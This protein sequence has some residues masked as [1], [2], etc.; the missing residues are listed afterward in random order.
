MAGH[1]KHVSPPESNSIQIFIS[2]TFTDFKVERDALLQR[3]FPALQQYARERGLEVSFAS[4][5]WGVSRHVNDNHEITQICIDEIR[6]VRARSIGVNFVGLLGQKYGYCPIPTSIEASTFD[7]LLFNC[8]AETKTLLSKWYKR[9]SNTLDKRFI[10]LPVSDVFEGYDAPK[11]TKEE[12]KAKQHEWDVEFAKLQSALRQISACGDARIPFEFIEDV[13]RS[14]TER[15]IRAALEDPNFVDNAMFIARRFSGLPEGGSKLPDKSLRRFIDV[16]GCEETG[17]TRDINASIRLERLQSSLTSDHAVNMVKTT[18]PWLG[19]HDGVAPSK[20]SEHRSYLD[21]LCDSFEAFVKASID[22]VFKSK[23]DK[24]TSVL[25]AELLHHAYMCQQK[26]IAGCGHRPETD[27]VLEYCLSHNI[28]TGNAPTADRHEMATIMFGPSGCGKTT[29]MATVISNLYDHFDENGVSSLGNRVLYRFLGTSPHSSTAR[30][31]LISLSMQ[32][33]LIANTSFDE[34]KTLALGQDDAVALFQQSLA[35]ASASQPLWLFLDSLDQLS[36][37]AAESVLRWLPIEFPSHVRVV[38]ST[39]NDKSYPHFHAIKGVV[40]DPTHHV[41]L[42]PFEEA[43]AQDILRDILRVSGRTLTRV[44]QLH[45]IYHYK[46]DPTPLFLKLA[47][48]TSKNWHSWT[49]IEECAI[50]DSVVGLIEQLFDRI[51]LQFGDVFTSTALRYVTLARSGLSLVELED[52]LSCNDTVLDSIFEWW[53]PPIRRIPPL[54]WTRIRHELGDFMV[55]RGE[56]GALVHVWFHRQ[57]IEGAQ[58][59]FGSDPELAKRAH[60]DMADYFLGKWADVSKPTNSGEPM[61]R[62]VAQQPIEF[63]LHDTVQYNF[64]KLQ[65]LPFHLLHAKRVEEALETTL[66]NVEFLLAKTRAFSVYM[67]IGDIHEAKDASWVEANVK[68]ALGVLSRTLFL[69]ANVL[70]HH[71]EELASQLLA[72]WSESLC[73]KHPLLAKLVKNIMESTAVAMWPAYVCLDGPDDFLIRTFSRHDDIVQTAAFVG[74]TGDK[75]ATSSGKVLRIWSASEGTILQEFGGFASSINGFAVSPDGSL[76][77]L[78]GGTARVFRAEGGDPVVTLPG[79]HNSGVEFVDNGQAILVGCRGGMAKNPGKVLKYSLSEP[80][81]PELVFD[82]G[83]RHQLMFEL[84]PSGKYLLTGGGNSTKLWRVDNSE[85]VAEYPHPQSVQGLGFVTEDEFWTTCD[86]R[87]LRLWRCD[88]HDEAIVTYAPFKPRLPN[89]VAA[90]V[91]VEPFLIIAVAS[92][93]KFIHLVYISPDRTQCG[94]MIVVEAHGGNMISEL[95]VS[96]CGKYLLSG[97]DEATARLWN[98]TAIL[99]STT[100]PDGA[101]N[102][103]EALAP[104]LH[105]QE[106]LMAADATGFPGHERELCRVTMDDSSNTVCTASYDKS[107]KVWSILNPCDMDAASITIPHLTSCLDSLGDAER[108]GVPRVYPLQHLAGR[109]ASWVMDVAHPPSTPQL[110]TASDDKTFGV[111]SFREGLPTAY[112]PDRGAAM[113]D[114]SSTRLERAVTAVALSDD[115]E[116]L[117]AAES[118]GQITVYERDMEH[119][120]TPIHTFMDLD[121]T[122]AQMKL[123]NHVLLCACGDHNVNVLYWSDEEQCLKLVR[124]L[125]GHRAQVLGV[126]FCGADGAVSC[127]YDHTARIWQVSSGE[128]RAMLRSTDGYV[129]S[130]CANMD[131]RLVAAGSNSCVTLWDTRSVSPLTTFHTDSKVLSV[132]FS[133]SCRALCIGTFRGIFT[134]LYL[135]KALQQSLELDDIPIGA[136]GSL[137]LDQ[138]LRP[139][140]AEEANL[141]GQETASSLAGWFM[142]R[143]VKNPMRKRRYL[144]RNGNRIEY[145]DGIQNLPNKKK[146]E[147]LL[148][149]IAEC[150]VEGNRLLLIEATRTWDLLEETAGMAHKWATIIEGI[151][152]GAQDA[153]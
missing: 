25:D 120:Y 81:V 76:V 152:H 66:L 147:I 22:K 142:K 117:F 153:K 18:L 53:T 104:K 59:R 37:H 111:Y 46:Q 19:P 50:A 136:I 91:Q 54:L 143:G 67:T 15:E 105:M 3:S 141:K 132:A 113:V 86:D 107:A 131:G 93:S 119:V 137:A 64:R 148:S 106:Q 127:G 139:M 21:L 33:M 48:V 109:H 1:P 31:V 47:A 87:F 121:K 71:P 124:R 73:S 43:Q 62:H 58:R 75:I 115:L 97:S 28:A 123:R 17:Y 74:N 96:S 27:T 116:H 32:L 45:I 63:R 133:D 145:F 52:V 98:L 11:A 12:L 13:H 102:V 61:P 44:Q 140:T 79:Y 90:V 26:V 34:A 101:S 14:V 40:R 99:Q 68:E 134:T 100:P 77:A 88:K 83:H 20:H 150:C 82:H 125:K 95:A 30:D 8:D 138:S 16:V 108:F 56:N 85:L 70:E 92:W 80:T 29:A 24:P 110:V 118:R 6:N 103:D 69:C 38:I 65:E 36:T 151:I 89:M 2:S 146:G 10:L 35:M 130:V 57:F 9:D 94:V 7:A 51:S 41:P 39:L 129:Y 72:R 128:Q 23:R 60:S 49:P 5:R 42:H 126:D 149:N 84:S 55:E 135:S 122:V 112:E 4:M 78:S 114:F 144:L